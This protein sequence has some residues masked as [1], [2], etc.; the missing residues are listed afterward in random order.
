MN[1]NSC[2][3]VLFFQILNKFKI[4]PASILLFLVTSF[5]NA[6]ELVKN[7]NEEIEFKLE[8]LS[9]CVKKS[10]FRFSIRDS[11]RNVFLNPHPESGIAILKNDQTISVKHTELASYTQNKI[12][13]KIVFSNNENA[14]VI[15]SVNRNYARFAVIPE[16]RAEHTFVIRIA[17][18]EPGYGLADNLINKLTPTYA[19]KIDE[20]G[21]TDITGF[22]DY[23]FTA[24]KTRVRLTSN[25]AIYP[26]NRF[27]VINIDPHKK[28]VISNE[29][30]I[31]QGSINVKAIDQ[32][33]FIFGSIP[34][35]YKTFLEIRN[36]SGYP[37]ML[38]KYE[39]FGVGWESW[40]ALAWNTNQQ[41]VMDDVSKYL[42]LNYPLRWMVVG[43]GFWERSDPKFHAT[44]S[45]GI[46]DEALYPD[47]DQLIDFAHSNSLK[48]IL[49][50]RISFI[51]DGPFS[52]EGRQKGYFIKEA[53]TAKV[54]N[55]SFPKSPVYLLDTTNPEAVDWYIEKCKIWGVDGFKEDLFGYGK[56]DLPDDKINPVNEKLMQ[57]GYYV[58][59]RNN[60]LGSNSDIHR[61]EDFNYNHD[62]DRGAIN[63]LSYAYSG[64]PFTYGDIVGGL[65]GGQN[66]DDEVSK[67]IKSYMMRISRWA[68]LHS[69]MAMGKGPWH[70]NDEQV[71]RII[72]GSAQLHDRLHPYIYSQALRFYHDGFPWT[73]APLPLMFPDDDNVHNRENNVVR[74]YQWMIGDA[75]MAYPLYG[76][77][78]ESAMS[79][80]VYL[81]EGT[82]ID[83]ESGE[84]YE[85][86]T[87]LKD[88]EIP[89]EK[90]PLFVGG[91]GILVEQD[92]SELVCKVFPVAQDTSTIFYHRDAISKSIISIGR[93]DWQNPLVRSSDGQRISVKNKRYYIQFK[94]N[95][96]TDYVIN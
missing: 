85:G 28:I 10:G 11:S 34:D 58:M 39:F 7:N 22:E 80:D 43:S 42:S 14:N 73:Q 75:L 79:R 64:I 17:G 9:F 48:I 90:I 29:N 31:V 95:P 21:G 65:F 24:G 37:I 62:Q 46:W 55:I 51:T 50:L 96:G 32:F 54:F 88:F 49:G 52:E 8:N 40:G 67:R 3:T 15:I 35:I 68:A 47:P 26:Q 23:S 59:G 41:T 81:P 83:Y 57:E 20:G 74:G 16:N 87:I 56:Y 93:P 2:K 44:T 82:W 63:T 86:N 1:K 71:E 13:F 92:D 89:F 27:A 5:L 6:Q 77:D 36:E 38:P 84:R 45:F 18:T 61:I 33:Y 91:T 12:N 4:I 53:D 70:F 76:E 30:E 66:F 19:I 78:Y 60:Y 94:L 69:S 25:F 72:L